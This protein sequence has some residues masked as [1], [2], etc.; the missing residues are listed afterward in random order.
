MSGRKVLHMAV[1]LVAV[2][3]LAH[4][5]VVNTSAANPQQREIAVLQD[6]LRPTIEVWNISRSAYEGEPFTAWADVRDLASGVRNVS[7]IVQDSALNRTE[8]EL[9]HNGSYYVASINRLQFNR[10]HE[11][12]ISAFDMA[13]NSATT[14]HLTVNLIE[15]TYTPVDPWVTMP[16]VVSSSLALMAMVIC[17]AAVYNKRRAWDEQ[18]E[19]TE[20]VPDEG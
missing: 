14:Y 17:L 19:P 15:S 2:M 9:L 20:T 4:G 16:T 8:Y 7:L 12:W 5:V 10:S 3:I 1:I 11:L 6:T 13:N 18:F